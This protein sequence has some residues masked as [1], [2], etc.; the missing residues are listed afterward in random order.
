MRKITLS[1]IFNKRSVC[2]VLALV[3]ALS[4]FTLAGCDNKDGQDNNSSITSSQ[5]SSNNS[6]NVSSDDA[7]SDNSSTEETPS[8]DN[9]SV[10]T[11]VAPKPVAKPNPLDGEIDVIVD[12]GTTLDSDDQ[13]EIKPLKDPSNLVNKYKGYAE[14]ERN[15]LLNDILNSENT[16]DIYDIKGKV[17]YVSPDGNDDNDGT[18]PKKPLRTL[19]AVGRLYL[20]EGDA[21]LFN[22]GHVYRI[23]DPF[24]CQ[25]GIT[26][27]SY[28][29]G[30]KP[31]FYGSPKNF[32]EVVWKPTK[33][34][35]VWETSYLYA[36][37]SGAFFDQGKEIGYMKSST[38]DLNKNTDYFCDT[39]NSTLYLYCDKGNPADAW[40][41][42]EL[43]QS[44]IRIEIPTKV[45]NV[46]ID[47]IA[48]RYCGEGGIRGEWLNHHINVTNCEIGFVGGA[49]LGAV[50]YGNGIEAWTGG[51][52]VNWSHN[53][54]Y[55]T[56]D[57]AVSPQ[58]KS[59]GDVVKMDNVN[60]SDN[61]F[62]FNNGDI[63][64]WEHGSEEGLAPSRF[65]DWTMENNI[66]RF[67][68]L[69]WGTRLDDGGIRGIDGVF[70]GRSSDN[71]FINVNYKNNIID[72]PGRMIYNFGM[73]TKEQYDGWTREN[74]TFY[75]KQSLRTTNNL[76][77]KLTFPIDGA[78]SISAVTEEDTINAF[79][80]FEPNSTVHW[81]K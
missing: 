43:S 49:W 30:Y 45:S 21:V 2:I 64:Y 65:K 29:K 66:H 63:E 69:G 33:K 51:W 23:Y 74:N 37:A 14:D 70:F 61:L 53:W 71:E 81:Y 60:I 31:M 67:T 39:D 13:F 1:D 12:L 56:F 34:R 20:E 17:Y 47:N 58:S 54:I 3:M 50:R 19:A 11:P 10:Q 78:T 57:S 72:C 9:S 40:D 52:N 7:F 68:S 44:G 8:E 77:A 24:Y 41:S 80:V 62:E 48:L 5:P 36:Y 28:G 75:I 26:Y 16:L 79:K 59:G 55:Q 22:R 27:G 73:S 6:S 76:T 32:A 18:S 15:S 25:T 35:N 38:G 4:M 46:T 42:I